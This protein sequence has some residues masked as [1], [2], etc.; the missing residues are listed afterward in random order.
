MYTHQKKY[1]TSGKPADLAKGALIML[2]GRGGAASNMLSLAAAL[3]VAELAIY[4]PQANQNSWY[5]YSFMA[6]D[7]DN[8]PALASALDM[9]GEVVDDILSAGISAEHIYFLGFSQGACLALEYISRNARHYGGA[10]AFTGGL[11]GEKLMKEHYRGSFAGT[12]VLIT[13]GDP[14][15][16]VPLSRVEASVRQLQAQ[17][18]NVKLQVY[19]GRSHMVTNDELKLA[20]EWV[21]NAV[22]SA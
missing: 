9:L 13:T 16:H 4:A 17:Q 15:P 6:P 7:S 21:F 19:K 3:N 10:V 20:D 22:T 11:I 14:D 18:G 5:P 8:Q 12:P 1:L 2:H